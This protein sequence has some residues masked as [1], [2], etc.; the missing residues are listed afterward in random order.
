[1]PSDP[2]FKLLAGNVGDALT[3]D[4][5]DVIMVA[6]P[7]QDVLVTTLKEQ[8]K[9]VKPGLLAKARVYVAADNAHMSAVR[10][11]LVPTGAK[12][13]QLDVAATIPQRKERLERLRRGEEA[14]E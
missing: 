4:M 6:S 9:R 2:H 10:A 3:D 7:S 13:I 12:V 14:E 1:L 11:A 5:S 8:A